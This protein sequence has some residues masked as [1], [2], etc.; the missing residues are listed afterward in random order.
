MKNLFILLLFISST[1]I[2]SNSNVATK[3]DIK[4]LIEQMREE[5]KIMREEHKT[6]REETNRR[7]EDINK[8][9][10]DTNRRFDDINKRFD[11]INKR[12]DDMRTMYLFSFSIIAAVLGALLLQIRDLYKSVSKLNQLVEAINK[13]EE[14]KFLRLLRN[15]DYET[16]QKFKRE[17]NEIL[18]VS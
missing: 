5:H 15:A 6:M 3:E 10:E 7:F 18:E 2:F 8:R 14:E 1:H 17:L 13:D 11:D 4:M 16:K 12:F 9:F